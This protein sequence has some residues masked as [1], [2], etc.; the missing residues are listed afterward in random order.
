MNIFKKIFKSVY[1]PQYYKDVQGQSF[2]YSLKYFFALSFWVALII[3]IVVGF[4]FLP[5]VGSFIKEAGN[6]IMEKFPVGLEL[7]IKNGVASTNAPEPIFIKMEPKDPK[8]RE[9]FEN[10]VVIDT[11]N[12]FSVEQFKSYKTAVWITRDSVVTTDSNGEIKMQAFSDMPES[13]RDIKINEQLLKKMGQGILPYVKYVYPAIVIATFVASFIAN[14]FRLFYLLFGALLVL[15]AFAIRGV[16]LGYKKAYQIGMHAITLGILLESFMPY[17]FKGVFGSG[18]I[19]YIF[20]VA[21]FIDALINA[22]KPQE[23]AVVK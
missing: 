4:T 14:L 5:F 23:L 7:S 6:K 15:A 21:L 12:T 1:S 18:G 11:K 10:I 22:Q 16:K 2:G 20:S 17:L 9:K 3:T 13:L 19:P 8:K